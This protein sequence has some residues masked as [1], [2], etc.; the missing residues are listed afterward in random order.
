MKVLT[1]NIDG[2]G[3]DYDKRLTKILDVIKLQNPDIIA[4]QEVKYGSYD[5]IL[6]FFDNYYCYLSDKVRYH[7]LYGEI[8]LIKCSD[9]VKDK[10]SAK[11]ISFTK[12]PNMRGATI[13]TINDYEIITTHLEIDNKYNQ[14]NIFELK[15]LIKKN[16]TILLGDFNFFD[17]ALRFDLTEVM[18]G[19]T[20]FSEK[21]TSR[22]DRVFFKGLVFDSCEILEDEYSDHK[23]LVVN[24]KS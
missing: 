21:Y 11:Y 5:K 17:N 14:N 18:S 13:Y 8:M 10:I 12:S 6:G 22:P 1:W 19:N 3:P 7:R 2:F 20:Y 4:L 24:F 16:K 23:C 9:K 15:N